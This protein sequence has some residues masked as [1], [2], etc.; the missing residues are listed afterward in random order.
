MEIHTEFNIGEKVYAVS[1]SKFGKPHVLGP[2][3]IGRIV[4]EITEVPETYCEET[5]K[6]TVEQSSYRESY[7]TIETGIGRGVLWPVML[8]Y[9]SKE[10]AEAYMHTLIDCS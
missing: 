4:V 5:M 7:M 3:T 6:K 8:V 10:E 9:G 1:R 2:Y